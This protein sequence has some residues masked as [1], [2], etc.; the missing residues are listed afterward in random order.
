MGMCMAGVSINLVYDELKQVRKELHELRGALIPG[1][2]ISKKEHAELDRLFAEMRQGK[3]T[4]W[5]KAL[6]GRAVCF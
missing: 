2:K 3:A 5:R 4:P 1:E 6:K